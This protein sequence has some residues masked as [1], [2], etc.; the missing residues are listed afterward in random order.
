MIPII[1]KSKDDGSSSSSRSLSEVSLSLH[2][3]N[4]VARMSARI[5]TNRMLKITTETGFWDTSDIDE[6]ITFVREENIMSSVY[7]YIIM[8]ASFW[9]KKSIEWI[10]VAK[11]FKRCEGVTLT[12]LKNFSHI[13]PSLYYMINYTTNDIHYGTTR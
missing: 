8:R 2:E 12:S 5:K 11:I 9:I 4:I 7:R 6:R 1:Q 3:G 13:A 10:Y